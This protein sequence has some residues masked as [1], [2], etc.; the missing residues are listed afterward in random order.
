MGCRS[1]LSLRPPTR[2]SAR[3]PPRCCAESRST[4]TPVIA[5]KGFAGEEFEA[6]MAE[7]GAIFVRPDRKGEKP[8]F[9]KL[10]GMRQWIESIIDT[11]KGQLSLERHGARTMPGLITRITQRLLALRPA[12]GTT[13]PSGTPTT[14][15]TPSAASSPTT[16][17]PLQTESFI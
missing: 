12:S 16:T 8:R 6:L 17:K 10:G 2:R 11:T 3:S 5:D 13:G 7:L 9:G 14:S 4:A 15:T 1:L